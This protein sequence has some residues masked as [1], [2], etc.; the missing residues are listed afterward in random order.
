MCRSLGCSNWKAITR[1]AEGARPTAG[2]RRRSHCVPR[3]YG[4]VLLPQSMPRRVEQKWRLPHTLLLGLSFCSVFC[5]A[6][7][8]PRNKERG[9]QQNQTWSKIKEDITAAGWDKILLNSCLFSLIVTR[10]RVFKE[11][12]RPGTIH[13]YLA[14]GSVNVNKSKLFLQSWHTAVEYHLAA[15]GGSNRR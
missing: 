4:S 12:P 15:A 7:T 6:A 9:L 14:S 8:P 1:T 3:P 10:P 13:R 11:G 2:R 5:K